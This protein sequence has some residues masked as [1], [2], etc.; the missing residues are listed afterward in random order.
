MCDA[1][2]Q[3]RFIS[4]A[5]A[6]KPAGSSAK[7]AMRAL[8]QARLSLGRTPEAPQSQGTLSLVAGPRPGSAAA[9][10]AIALACRVR[11]WELDAVERSI[12]ASRRRQQLLGPPRAAASGTT[13]GTGGLDR[14]F[15]WRTRGARVSSPARALWA[16]AQRGE[17]CAGPRL[18]ERLAAAASARAACPSPEQQLNRGGQVYTRP[19]AEPRGAK[20][21]RL[22][23]L[24]AELE[25]HRATAAELE[26]LIQALEREIEADV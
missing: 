7:P 8:R 11:P 2:A 16:A 10:S 26:R 21:V 14:T 22:E 23:A 4:A 3:A 9:P 25:H 19:A 24:R 6:S 1:A 12:R 20:C 15:P 18:P 17:A 13:D 5:Q